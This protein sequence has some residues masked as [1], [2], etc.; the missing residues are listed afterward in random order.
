MPGWNE[1][2]GVLQLQEMTDYEGYPWEQLKPRPR[3]RGR[4]WLWIG[5]PLFVGVAVIAGLISM[6]IGFGVGT[7]SVWADAS[8]IIVLLPLFLLGFI[9]LA[10]LIGLSYGAARLVSW[11]PGPLDQFVGI[12]QR[13][14]RETRRGG[15]LVARPM[16]AFQGIM[17][18][19]ANFL[20]G[21]IE[22]M[23]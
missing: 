1:A 13:V 12:M 17:A 4:P 10:L 14:A 21:W 22:I 23:R 15:G 3:R 5:I 11:L 6:V 7:T 18:A 20:R 19:V 2:A 8:L 9:P 16:V